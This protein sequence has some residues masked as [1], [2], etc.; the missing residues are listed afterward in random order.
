MNTPSHVAMQQAADWYALLISGEETANDRARWKAWLVTNP[1]HRQAWSYVETVS[2]RV[3]APLQD[4]PDPHLTAENLHSANTRTWRRRHV[5]TGVVVAT[6]ASALGWMGWRSSPGPW[7][8][9]LG[10]DHRTGVGEIREIQLPDGTRVWLNTAS[11]FNQQ[12]SA[13]FRRLQLLTGEFLVDTAADDFKRPFIVETPQ[14]RLRALGTRFTVR[15]DN[16]QTVLAVYQGAVEIRTA[17]SGD[18]KTIGAGQQTRFNAQGI[19]PLTSTDQ[20][21]AAWS[22]GALVALDIPLIEVVEELR[23]YTH[24]HIGVDPAVAQQRVFGSFPLHDVNTTLNLLAHAATLRVRRTLPWWV[25]LEP[26]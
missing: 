7:V 5:L 13:D 10:A 9:A 19:R 8:L 21:G 11:A 18:V 25:T 16:E 17:A 22:R 15:Q 20:S 24:Q 1:E 2:Q 4:T 26:L 6:S 12:Y 23:R 14:G 3:L